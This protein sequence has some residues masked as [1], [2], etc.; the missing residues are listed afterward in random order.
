M[1]EIQRIRSVE[2]IDKDGDIF[3][4]LQNARNGVEMGNGGKWCQPK[5]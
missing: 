5:N 2:K 3:L 1:A 4:V